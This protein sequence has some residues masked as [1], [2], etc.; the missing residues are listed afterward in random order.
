MQKNKPKITFKKFIGHLKVVCKHRFKVFCLCVR[1][2]IIWR[3]LVHDL[4][5]FSPNEFIESVR[6]F[7]G[8][9]SPISNCKKE[10][11]YSKAWLHHKGRNKHHYEYCYDL[12]S[13]LP[14]IPYPY[15][16]EMICD[17]IA[18]GMTYL[19]KKW[20]KDYQLKYFLIH[21]DSVKMP[22]KM[23]DLL[24]RVYTDISKY[25]INKV[26][27]KKNL[28]ALYNEYTK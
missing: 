6:Y 28:K 10:N 26:V 18:A 21:K 16:A 7:S 25:G 5:K 4:S 9:K 13:T 20:T 22:K 1:A 15:F 19:G 23:I 17:N 24:N 14:I 8:D 12:T 3:G 11:G 2:G 27:N